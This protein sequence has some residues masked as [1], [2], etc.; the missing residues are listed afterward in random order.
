MTSFLRNL[1]IGEQLTLVVIGLFFVAMVGGA[2][3]VGAAAMDSVNDTEPVGNET[4]A[5][6]TANIAWLNATN[7]GGSNSTEIT[8]YNETGTVLWQTSVRNEDIGNTEGSARSA[9]VGNGEYVYVASNYE[10]YK[11][12]ATTGE[13]INT[14]GSGGQRVALDPSGNLLTTL[15]HQRQSI[16][17]DTVYSLDANGTLTVSDASY[18]GTGNYS[19]TT[20][21]EYASS[22]Y[23]TENISEVAHQTHN[24]VHASTD[25]Y[26]VISVRIEGRSEDEWDTHI[27]NRSTGESVYEIE[28]TDQGSL[29]TAA[30]KPNGTLIVNAYIKP[31]ASAQGEINETYVEFDTATGTVVTEKTGNAAELE[32]D[33]FRNSWVSS[34]EY[35][36]VGEYEVS[37][38]KASLYSYDHSYQ[39]S[40]YN[41][42]GAKIYQNDSAEFGPNY[43]DA[44]GGTYD[45]EVDGLGLQPQRI[46]NT[47]VYH[48][49]TNTQSFSIEYAGTGTLNITSVTNDSGT[50]LENWSVQ[51]SDSSGETIRSAQNTT[52]PV[53]YELTAGESYTVEVSKSGFNTT[54]QSVSISENNTTQVDLTLVDETT[55]T[56]TDDGGDETTTDDGDD[57][58][59]IV[60]GGGGDDGT[61]DVLAVV[62]GVGGIGFLI[63][64]LVAV[65]AFRSGQQ[66]FALILVIL[67]LSMMVAPPMMVGDVTAQT[68][69]SGPPEEVA[70]LLVFTAFEDRNGQ[71]IKD[72]VYA[73]DPSTNETAWVTELNAS[74]TGNESAIAVAS[75]E[76]AHRIYA[77]TIGDNDSVRAYS[78]ESSSG[79]IVESHKLNLTS[80]QLGRFAVAGDSSLYFNT[81]D[82]TY[83][84]DFSS[85][86]LTEMYTYE[87]VPVQAYSMGIQD[88]QLEQAAYAPDLEATFVYEGTN[89]TDDFGGSLSRIDH[90]TQGYVYQTSGESYLEFRTDGQTTWSYVESES[91]LRAAAS[92]GTS[93]YATVGD[94]LRQ[95]GTTANSDET[96]LYTANPSD[97]TSHRLS[98]LEYDSGHLHQF[99]T[100]QGNTENLTSDTPTLVYR[101]HDPSTGDLVY[102][103]KIAHDSN[104][105]RSVAVVHDTDKISA[106]VGGSEP[107]YSLGDILDEYLPTEYILAGLGILFVAFVG[108]LLLIWK[109]AKMPLKIL[110]FPFKMFWKLLK[111][112]RP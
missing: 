83:S 61:T 110:S 5:K 103:T 49:Q 54:Q 70:D 44:Y 24:T 79:D 50:E 38:N 16:S 25:E 86:S 109:V 93:V 15:D 97:K 85:D 23:E 58:G 98:T 21:A 77:L 68:T 40:I 82:K 67:V 87:S 66:Q 56:T 41:E 84:F 34:L 20:T 57:V 17:K 33:F 64:L 88:G 8:A 42:S 107:A 6:T 96:V 35:Y 14:T 2:A 55:E 65:L 62:F 81:P 90:T 12:N 31:D 80:Y 99:Q 22:S 1:S 18:D 74:G 69:E 19:T 102:E 75:D 105:H 76:T 3:I 72:T 78:L 26:V 91:L 111:M 108:I 95:Y 59:V 10:L 45:I 104:Y 92:D 4:D 106:I 11:L 51:V 37:I 30:V 7:W 46:N 32:H 112:L 27:V 13:L 36:A 52:A 89:R 29:Q 39:I 9:V 60:P 28:Y 48:A 101:M 43:I 71:P 100:R 94:E 47:T 63:F 53:E 73:V